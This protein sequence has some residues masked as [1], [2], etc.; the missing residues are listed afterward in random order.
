MVRGL[1]AQT[2]KLMWPACLYHPMLPLMYERLKAGDRSPEQ[3]RGSRQGRHCLMCVADAI[4][5]SVYQS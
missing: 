3:V 4:L 2:C 1:N 5:V